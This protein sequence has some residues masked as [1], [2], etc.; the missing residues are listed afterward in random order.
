MAEQR[1]EKKERRELEKR[2]RVPALRR[3]GGGRNAEWNGR[4]MK[5]M[6]LWSRN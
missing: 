5:V 6:K 4:M 3:K 1:E 2:W